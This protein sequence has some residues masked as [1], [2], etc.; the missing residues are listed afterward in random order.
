MSKSTKYHTPGHSE[1]TIFDKL[2]RKLHF[3]IAKW[4]EFKGVA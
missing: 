2:V 3:A 1:A 4:G